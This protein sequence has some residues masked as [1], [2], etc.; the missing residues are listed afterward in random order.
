MLDDINRVLAAIEA[1]IF[2]FSERYNYPLTPIILAIIFCHISFQLKT[3]SNLV[4][5]PRME[6]KTKFL[7]QFIQICKENRLGQI[8]EETF[9]DLW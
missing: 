3:D 1:L 4:H 7:N 9:S 6:F 5:T 2:E 8:Q